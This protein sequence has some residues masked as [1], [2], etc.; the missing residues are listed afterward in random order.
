M[1]K[2]LAEK[3]CVME[4]EGIVVN[5]CLE[6]DHTLLRL[7]HTHTDGNHEMVGLLQSVKYVELVSL[8]VSII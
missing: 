4:A 3:V 2:P 8:K 7:M 1:V 5:F 6:Q